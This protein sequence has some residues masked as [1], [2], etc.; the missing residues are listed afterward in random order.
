MMQ[1]ASVLKNHL[2]DENFK[3]SVEALTRVI[4]LGKKAQEKQNVIDPA[5]FE[6]ASEKALYQ[7]VEKIKA[8]F[9]KQTL[10]ENYQSLVSLAPFIEEYFNET[11][12]MAPDEKVRNNRLSQLKQ[13]ADL[14]FVLA[15][16]DLL[17]V[18]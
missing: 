9:K 8:Q 3:P 10:E 7:Q 18:K 17:N 1:A 6:N 16:F 15:S 12:V 5:L 13:I 2:Q 14:A 4:N 11:M